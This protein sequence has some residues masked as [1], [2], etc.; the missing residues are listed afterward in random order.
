MRSPLIPNCDKSGSALNK[1]DRLAPLDQ[2]QVEDLKLFQHARINRH[3]IDGCDSR[4]ASIGDGSTQQQLSPH[5]GYSKRHASLDVDFQ[6]EFMQ[7]RNFY[8]HLPSTTRTPHREPSKLNS[9]LGN[10]LAV[11]QVETQGPK[12]RLTNES[13]QKS[14]KITQLE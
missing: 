7:K 8:P 12:R 3:P 14:S 4:D 2:S 10:I 9:D 13:Q 6:V 11:H 1:L 5:K